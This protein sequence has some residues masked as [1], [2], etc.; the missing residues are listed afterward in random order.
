[1]GGDPEPKRTWIYLA[2]AGAGAIV[3]W[4]GWQSS[5]NWPRSRRIGLAILGI[6]FAFAMLKTAVVREHAT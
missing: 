3:V 4:A 2:L 1:M 5:R 6:V